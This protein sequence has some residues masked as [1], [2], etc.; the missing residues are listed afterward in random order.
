[1]TARDALSLLHVTAGATIP[2]SASDATVNSVL[3]DALA[4]SNATDALLQRKPCADDD[5][6]L[7][8]P[9]LDLDSGAKR[10]LGYEPDLFPLFDHIAVQ[11]CVLTC[12]CARSRVC[13]RVAQASTAGLEG[14]AQGFPDYRPVNFL[15]VVDVVKSWDD[16][17]QAMRH[18]DR[19][20]WFLTNQTS[21]QR[22]AHLR[23]ALLQ[24]L[25]TQVSVRSLHR[26]LLSTI[27]ACTGVADAAR[28][29]IARQTRRAL[30]VGRS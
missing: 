9:P 27:I 13:D 26:G 14:S 19:L 18:V 22:G 20:C 3:S 16:A 28:S 25:F 11:V 30:H 2:T 10:E 17:V 21:I 12:V 23:V 24:H 15:D 4:L 1:V 8:P 5:S 7:P 29:Q 6:S